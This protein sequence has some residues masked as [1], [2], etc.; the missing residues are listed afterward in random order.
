L[1]S[2]TAMYGNTRAFTSFFH[3]LLCWLP[4]LVQ[5]EVKTVRPLHVTV[6][7]AGDG[8]YYYEFDID[9]FSP[10]WKQPWNVP[11]WI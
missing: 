1:H 4:V 9:R 3:G 5:R 10:G 7:R 8:S 6:Q 11:R 2:R